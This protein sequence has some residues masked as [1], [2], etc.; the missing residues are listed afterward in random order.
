LGSLTNTYED[1][2]RRL[3]EI[4]KASPVLSLKSPLDIPHIIA[5]NDI[6]REYRGILMSKIGVIVNCIC[7]VKSEPKPIGTI[8]LYGPEL[9]GEK[10]AIVNSP[11]FTCLKQSWSNGEDGAF[12]VSER[13]ILNLERLPEFIRRY[14]ENST[15]NDIV[16]TVEN[17]STTEIVQLAYDLVF[18]RSKPTGSIRTVGLEAFSTIIV[19]TLCRNFS[20]GRANH[21]FRDARIE[22]PSGT[23]KIDDIEN[24]LTDC[25]FPYRDCL[26]IGPSNN[27]LTYHAIFFLNRVGRKATERSLSC[28]L[29]SHYLRDICNLRREK[30]NMRKNQNTS[31]EDKL[32]STDSLGKRFKEISGIVARNVRR[33]IKS[34]LV[35][36][37][38][39]KTGASFHAIGHII[40]TPYGEIS[41]GEDYN[42]KYSTA[43]RN[44]SNIH[45]L[46]LRRI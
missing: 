18:E 1:C 33:S 19:N 44:I 20:R 24:S 5:R 36:K 26:K 9:F 46:S 21:L 29:A 34:L 22:R 3:E 4:K 30:D 7:E 35:Q 2:F 17:L 43:L 10:E 28:L 37:V 45:K 13:I 42:D 23:V 27:L 41:L 25:E 12:G 14:E 40:K 16:A 11:Y 15:I 39:S 38:I 31:E 6:S 32:Q 8:Y